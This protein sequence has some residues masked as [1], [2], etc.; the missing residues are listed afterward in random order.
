MRLP[1]QLRNKTVTI[2]DVVDAL[3]MH[4]VETRQIPACK[5]H[6]AKGWVFKCESTELARKFSGIKVRI[7]DYAVTT[8]L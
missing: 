4:Q 3:C 7:Q 8:T 6:D 1:Q 5:K 2:A